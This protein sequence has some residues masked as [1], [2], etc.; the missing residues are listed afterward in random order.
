MDKMTEL[1]LYESEKYGDFYHPPDNFD[2]FG[3]AENSRLQT[4]ARARTLTVL[5]D[6]DGAHKTAIVLFLYENELIVGPEPLVPLVEASLEDAELGR[7]VLV[8]VNFERA[9]LNDGKDRNPGGDRVGA[10]LSGVVAPDSNF[11]R[12]DLSDA[13]LRK[14]W[15]G[16]GPD[17]DT[18][19][20]T[21]FTNANLRDANLSK[22]NLV[23]VNLTDANLTRTNLAGAD[24]S[25]ANLTR[26]YVNPKGPPPP[27]WVSNETLE[28]RDAILEGATMPDG[29]KYEDWLKD[30]GSG[31][32]D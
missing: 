32:E 3:Q 27:E 6:L 16:D 23:G 21:N 1:I 20:E 18:V 5:D 4:L 22:A 11:F 2:G 7:F 13:E 10:R 9:I 12:A 28:Q 31:A 30:E 24:L 25:G 8:G 26:A 29:R 15:F 17:E 19:I 14:A